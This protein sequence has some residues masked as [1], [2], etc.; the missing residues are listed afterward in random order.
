MRKII[1]LISTFLIWS[2]ANSQTYYQVKAETL[3]VRSSADKEA[4]IIGKLYLGDSVNV[5]EY[6]EG[7][8]KVKLNQ[9]ET[10][11]VATKYI[12]S[13]FNS[14]SYSKSN[15]KVDYSNTDFS[16]VIYFLILAIVLY[17]IYRRYRK[18]CEKCGKWAA[19]KRTDSEVVER[20]N[21]HIK[22]TLKDT[23]NGQTTATHEV[24]VPAT[25]TKYLI[26]ETCKHC[27][28]DT[29]FYESETTEN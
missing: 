17:I 18:R 7:W 4:E 29:R 15:S 8:S 1:T 21:S 26:T 16:G 22:K 12:S 5:I 14:N 28:H 10:G 11:Y 13:E 9:N 2:F 23:H 19:M 6:G 3:N 24:V 27:G 20:L 25:K